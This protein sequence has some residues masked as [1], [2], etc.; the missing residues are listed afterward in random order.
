[1]CVTVKLLFYQHAMCILHWFTAKAMC[2]ATDVQ[3]L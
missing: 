3:G 2:T 1:M